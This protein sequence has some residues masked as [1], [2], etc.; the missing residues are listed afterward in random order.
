MYFALMDLIWQLMSLLLLCLMGISGENVLKQNL[1][2]F[3]N[4]C[5]QFALKV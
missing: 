5:N 4:G 1:T 2:C 3:K